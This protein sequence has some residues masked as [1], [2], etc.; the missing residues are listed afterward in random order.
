MRFQTAGNVG[1][2]IGGIRTADGS[3]EHGGDSFDAR[4]LEPSGGISR[5]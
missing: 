4:D 3:E 2:N 1:A 5:I